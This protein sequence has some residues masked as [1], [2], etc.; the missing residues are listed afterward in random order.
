MISKEIKILTILLIATIDSIVTV[1]LVSVGYGELNPFMNWI[2]SISNVSIM[3][4]VKLVLFTVI[5]LIFLYKMKIPERLLTFAIV[6]YLTLF[7]SAMLI[8]LV[9]L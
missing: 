9:I 8:Q 1:Y 2:L 6:A 5:P 4:I 7:S 3:V